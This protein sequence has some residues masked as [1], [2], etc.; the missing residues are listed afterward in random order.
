MNPSAE[1][2]FGCSSGGVTYEGQLMSPSIHLRDLLA[3]PE[4]NWDESS[5]STSNLKGSLSHFLCIF[6]QQPLPG[7]CLGLAQLT[8]KVKRFTAKH[9]DGS[10]FPVEISVSKG[11][12]GK[13][14]FY[15]A[16]VRNI[17]EK[18]ESELKLKVKLALLLTMVELRN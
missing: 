12:H 3:L 2:M 14:L 11:V 16:I 17:T 10:K 6:H 7:L 9:K 4:R 1:K 15:V 18:L 8:G 13:T 5:A